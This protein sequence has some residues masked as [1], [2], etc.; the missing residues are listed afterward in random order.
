MHVSKGKRNMFIIIY[1]TK[2]EIKTLY[3]IR[4][5]IT[6]PEL[7][8]PAIGNHLC[9]RRNG[10]ED[11]IAATVRLHPIFSLTIGAG[12]MDTIRHNGS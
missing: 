5:L 1:T 10:N 6:M 8:L 9:S 3:L 2:I 4:G 12:H 7:R 11:K